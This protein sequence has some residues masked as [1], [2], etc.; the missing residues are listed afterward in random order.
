MEVGDV[1]TG[2]VPL[3]KGNVLVSLD[4]PDETNPLLPTTTPDDTITV[5]YPVEKML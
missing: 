4:M 5:E 1:D 3:P 2:N